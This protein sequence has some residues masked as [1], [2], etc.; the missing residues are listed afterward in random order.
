MSE[1]YP[2]SFSPIKLGPVDISNR[3][4]FSP[5]GSLM[6]ERMGDE[7][8]WYCLERAEDG[9][10]LI[11]QSTY[12]SPA[13]RPGVRSLYSEKSIPAFARA[14]D[15]LHE[16]D[17]KIFAE[18]FYS[19]LMPGTWEYSA[20]A[21]PTLGPSTAQ[22]FDR[23]AVGREMSGKEIQ[24]MHDAFVRCARNAREA[25]YDGFELHCTHGMLHEQ[26][27]SPYWNQRQDE[28]GGSDDNRLR[29]IR[30]ALE[31]I[32]D[33]T[34]PDMAVG[35]R[36]NCDEMLPGGLDQQA[37]TAALVRIVD[38]GLV[39]FVDLD[40][41]VEPQQFPLGMP[42][43]QL[44]KFTYESYVA[45]VGKHIKSV[46]VLSCLARVTSIADVEA[47]LERGSADMVGMARGLI[48][49]PHLVK[50]ARE[51]KES[52]SRTCIACNYCMDHSS[53]IGDL[54][55]C[56]I[57]PATSR[58]GRWGV[59]TT[60]LA[61]EA[62][63]VVVVGGG[64]A[65]L[66]AARV[67]AVRGHDVVLFEK[68]ERLGGQYKGW[69]SLPGREDLFQAIDWYVT[70]LPEVGVEVRTGTAASVDSVLAENPDSV[71]VGTGS[72]Y[73]RNG[74]S[75]FMPA[76][77][78]G[79]DL[80]FVY[81]P[82]Q[83]IEEGARPGGKVLILDDEALNTGIGIAEILATEGAQVEFVTRWLNVAHNQFFTFEL[84][85]M[86]A[87]LKNLGVQ[88]TDQAYLK[89][90]GDH[91]ATVFDVFTNVETTRT[92]IDAVVLSTMR[93]PI[94]DLHAELEGR[95]EQLFVI[96]DAAGVRDHGAAFYEGSY[97]ARM[98][99]EPDAP[100][101]FT[102]AYH[103]AFLD[104]PELEPIPVAGVPVKA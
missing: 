36:Y 42:N 60:S 81:T 15:M 68:D 67:A 9:L 28:Y 32:R 58:E 30:E 103:R 44:P 74:A 12:L 50:H 104:R 54:F 92:G 41:T 84:P 38:D 27:L 19:P 4:Y 64:P 69:S 40:V 35:V 57:N 87:T 5:H 55:G 7:W 91:E 78:P 70:E 71:L 86:I 48:A 102:E 8:L 65:G 62:N 85:L 47:A 24:A 99:G 3:V 52:R 93:V 25:G 21:R 1:K 13:I 34:G 49:E 45:G 66:E 17:T 31:A 73:A 79:W 100:K 89:E 101:S 37:A 90:I 77:L 76:A 83:I 22:Q 33:A 43:Y 75:G 16:Y 18:I 51:G 10:G 46:P 23:F 88:L 97:F 59:R 26:F 94:D 2:R 61:P 80:P 98:I 56:A 20:P 39:D 53:G 63:K 29:F 96:G 95:V 72:R 14:A 6:S 82:E 11:I